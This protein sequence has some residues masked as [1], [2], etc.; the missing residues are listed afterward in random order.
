M[1]EV[2][3]RVKEQENR[4]RLLAVALAQ[5]GFFTASQA[6]AA[7]VAA[8]NHHRF[9]SSGAWER[10]SRGLFRLPSVPLPDRPDLYAV[11]LW[12]RDSGGLPRAVVSHAS[13]LAIHELGD[14]TPTGS[15]DV[16]VPAS[17]RASIAPPYEVR[18]H[19][20]DLPDSDV[21]E[22]E[23]FRLTRPLRSIVDLLREGASQAHQLREALRDGL[24]RGKITM[25]ELESASVTEGERAILSSWV[26]GR[27]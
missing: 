2:N 7:G 18:I 4:S 6:V 26:G 23:G 15:L 16:T 25:D 3:T 27:P 9:A 21:E 20:G 10:I 14:V 8:S 24:S 13:A 19:K 22:R 11:N 17:F 1:N 5:G 12:S